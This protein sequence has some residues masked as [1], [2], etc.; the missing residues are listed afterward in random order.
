MLKQTG[1]LLACRFLLVMVPWLLVSELA[2]AELHINWKTPRNPYVREALYDLDQGNYFSAI[3]HLMA[4]R[5]RKG[6]GS[7]Q[8]QAD[9]MLAFVLLSYGMHHEATKIL[10][11][12]SESGKPPRYLDEMWMELAKMRYQRGYLGLAEHA[13]NQITDSS[14]YILIEEKMNLLA[15]VYMAQNKNADAINS[16]NTVKGDSDWAMIARFNLGTTMVRRGQTKLGYSVLKS[17]THL[18]GDTQEMLALIDRVNYT[19]G[20]TAIREGK[21]NEAQQYFKAVRLESPYANGAMLGLGLAHASSQNHTRAIAAWQ[22][23]V[24]RD[25][26]SSSVLEALL[27]IPLSYTELGAHN[28]STESYQQALNTYRQEIRRIDLIAKSIEDGSLIN[29]LLQKLMNDG[30]ESVDISRVPDL[31]EFIYLQNLYEGHPFQLAITNYRDL[32]LMEHRLRQWTSHIYQIPD[33]SDTFKKVY[34]NQIAEKQTKLVTAAEEL[35]QHIARLA[36]N[37]LQKRKDSIVNYTRNALFAMAQN[38]DTNSF[39]TELK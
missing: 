31:P 38:Y 4:E 7:S 10:A 12:L 2:L 23:L 8:Q 5:K 34:V 15:L 18:Q 1:R 13:L 3:G 21:L 30:D 11:E 39:E 17:M 28:Q 27:A 6:F 35:R 19:L 36:I 32:R 37:E 24:K 25:P 20:Y 29:V 33:M 22:E 14:R 9:L 16:L 26:S